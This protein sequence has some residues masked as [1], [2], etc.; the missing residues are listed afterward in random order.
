MNKQ[1]LFLPF[2]Y[3]KR[4]ILTYLSICAILATGSLLKALQMATTVKS[5]LAGVGLTVLSVGVLF[6]MVDS[7]PE[8]AWSQSADQCV[9]VTQQGEKIPNGCELVA[10]GKIRAE[11]YIVK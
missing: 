3:K 8:M 6:Y 4:K 11:R 5:A 9:S 10:R 7:T 1:A 2:L